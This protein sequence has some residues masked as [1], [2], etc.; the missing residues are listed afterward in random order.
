MILLALG[1]VLDLWRRSQPV[2][3]GAISPQAQLLHRRRRQRP[4]IR[5][6]LTK[7]VHLLNPN[8]YSEMSEAADLMVTVGAC[9][10]T[11]TVGG[12]VLRKHRASGFGFPQF[13]AGRHPAN[14][15]NVL[16]LSQASTSTPWEH[17]TRQFCIP[18][19]MSVPLRDE[20]NPSMAQ[21]LRWALGEAGIIGQ[22]LDHELQYN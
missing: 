11:Q 15:D 7:L 8:P 12:F 13:A 10:S 6:K 16:P 18:L 2:I 17:K 1:M 4:S 19:P 22:V 9:P 3:P 5:Q 20:V 21:W 14:F